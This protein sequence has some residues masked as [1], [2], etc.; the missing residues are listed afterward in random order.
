MDVDGENPELR[1]FATHAATRG[2][3]AWGAKRDGVLTGLVATW[4]LG[5][6]AAWEVARMYVAQTERGSGLAH[7][8]LDMAEARA[9]EAGAARL[10]LW[11]DTRFEAAHRF[12]EKRSYVRAGSIRILDDKSRSLE[13]RYAKPVSGLAVEALDAAASASAE[14]RL[15]EVLVACVDAGAAVSFLPPLNPEAARAHWRKVSA[16]VAAGA[17]LLL[18]A[19]ADGVLAGTVMLDLGTPQNQPHRAEVQKLLVHPAFRRRGIARALM[20][21][22]EQAAS[23]IGRRL[24]TLDTRAGDA[25]EPLYRA[26]GWTEAGR[27]PGYALDADG[28][29]RDTVFFYKVVA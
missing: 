26:L 10:V 6:D 8:L 7:T 25:A 28:T 12:Y 5:H 9:R 16:D 21:R 1:A 3:V 22:A 20:E 24:L 13:F 19:W 2:G 11:S 29:A 27:I 4:P 17:R 18:A 15:S 14:R 23:R